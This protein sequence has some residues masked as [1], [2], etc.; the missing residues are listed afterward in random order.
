MGNKAEEAPHP[1]LHAREQPERGTSS[2][3]MSV[4]DADSFAC[5]RDSRGRRHNR[6][7]SCRVSIVNPT[8]EPTATSPTKQSDSASRH[9]IKSSQEIKSISP[10]SMDSHVVTATSQPRT[11][12]SSATNAS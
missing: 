10:R 8:L 11:R 6:F 4:V 9:I 1:I 2:A 7:L 12:P 5:R 3:N